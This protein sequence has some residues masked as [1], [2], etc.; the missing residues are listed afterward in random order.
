MHRAGS[1]ATKRPSCAAA[2]YAQNPHHPTSSENRRASQ[3]AFDRFRQELNIDRPHEV[4]DRQPPASRSA[5]SPRQLSAKPPPLE[6]PDRF[7][8]RYVSANGGIRW[9][10]QWVHVSI[11]CAGE[12]VGLEEIDHGV[13]NVDFGALKLDRLL[14]RH[15][16]IEDAYGRLTRH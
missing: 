16:R 15:R 4:L 8:G 7:E 10:R 3:H 14:E 1:T 9:N 12:D 13:W 6:Y 2:A 5:S 11:C